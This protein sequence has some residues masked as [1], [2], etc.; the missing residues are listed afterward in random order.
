MSTDRKRHVVL[1]GMM[2]SGK[3]TVGALVA[4]RL[5]RPL[6]DLDEAIETRAEATISELFERLGEDGF[7][8]LEADLLER[9]LADPEPTIVSTGGGAVLSGSNRRAMALAGRVVWL[10]ADPA[11]LRARIGDQPGRPLLNDDPEA[12]LRRLDRERAVVYRDVADL[13]IDVDGLDP[14]A[15]A[16]S[17]ESAVTP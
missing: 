12:V 15:V 10:R 2:G 6:V 4:E 9:V 7:R 3:S 11:T 17:V 5:G 1:V 16:A 13:V 8:D 14:A